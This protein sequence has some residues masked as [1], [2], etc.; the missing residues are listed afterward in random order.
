[1]IESNAR[2]P[3]AAS[4]GCLRGRLAMV[5]LAAG[6][7][8]P[9]L[10]AAP[11]NLDEARARAARHATAAWGPQ[12]LEQANDSR[13]WQPET[14]MYQ[15]VRTG[16]EVW[17][18]TSTPSR[19]NFFHDDI[20]MSPWSADGKRLAF[21]S[22]RDTA[23]FN[24]AGERVWFVVDA[25]G[26]RCRPVVGAPSRVYHHTLYFHWSPQL[27]DV[28][29]EFGRNAGGATGLKATDLYKAVVTDSGVVK[30]L[31]I[32]FPAN[33][34][35]DLLLQKTVSADGRRII[36]LPWD[37]HW[38]F[39]ATV[40]PEHSAGLLVPAGY[41]VNR[42]MA[43]TYGD[44]PA[45]YQSLH[46]HYYPADGSWHF[47]LPSGSHAWWRNRVL[48]SSPDGGPAFSFSPP[49]TFGD[50]WPE[51]T[52]AT[53]G[54]SPDP[55]GAKYW[56][57]FTP[58]RWG[59]YALQSNGDAVPSGSS[60][61]D[62]QHH[63]YV[64][65]TF[66]GG[67]E[68]Q[69]WSG[70]TDFIASSRGDSGSGN[71]ADDRLYVAAYNNPGSQQTVA[72]THTLFNSNGVWAGA[73]TQY[74]SLTRPAQS[75]DGTKIAFHSTF[76]NSNDG[77]VDVLWAVAYYPFPPN[78]LS[79]ATGG[80][81]AV[82]WLPAKYTKRGWPYAVPN[83][84]KDSAGWCAL[85]GAGNEIGEPL[86]A[87]ETK[88][89]HVW[90]SPTGTDQWK[91]VGSV[92]AQYSATYP[93]SSSM[94]MLHPVARG[95][96]VDEGNKV[97]FL[98]NPGNGTFYYAVTAEE[99]SGLESRELSEVLRVTVGRGVVTQATVV[100]PQGQ[101]GFF[102]APPPAPS[103]ATFQLA[104]GSAYRLNWKEPNN[105]SIR[106]YNIYY[107]SAGTPAAVQAQRIA[108]V[109]VGTSTYLDWLADKARPG[110]Y[111]VTSVDRQGNEGS[112]PGV[113]PGAPGHLQ[114]TR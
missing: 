91:E 43:H 54:G 4:P 111:R 30:S 72:Y 26:S 114:L 93:E 66:G 109:P 55:F 24:R 12:Y 2:A 65:Y 95:R 56:S 84:K 19:L 112:N 100:Q 59:R 64:V 88:S 103:P 46:D 27:P 7:A 104:A 52:V 105:H 69:D 82:E 37:E 107:S 63:K 28:Y 57:H 49:A 101:K 86:Y 8:A 81:V 79:A 34:G 77:S 74:A 87:R 9:S 41:S 80:G 35:A 20:S 89:Y 22:D 98:D 58:D 102:R 96:K 10:F 39:P 21:V 90:R 85:D 73:A 94:F 16:H 40:F 25:N 76:L 6:A 42:Q 50:E 51:N 36:A 83:P 108:S 53:Y 113:Q 11:E 99:H 70:F 78:R 3:G 60:V 31:L 32:S 68:H 5:L 110:F 29:Y 17:R 71:F 92:Q 18:M 1:M 23:A 61:W 75:P 15:D 62:I 38:L 106:Y 33:Q 44:T 97:R 67:A 48:G 47:V 45:S 13:Y 14:L